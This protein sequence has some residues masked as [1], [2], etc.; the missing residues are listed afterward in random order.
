M[1]MVD[2][3]CFGPEDIA[4]NPLTL[5]DVLTDYGA[6]YG[7]YR[8]DMYCIYLPYPCVS[9]HARAWAWFQIIKTRA[10]VILGEP[11]R[12]GFAE[13]KDKLAKSNPKLFV[14]ESVVEFLVYRVHEDHLK[15][16]LDL[17]TMAEIRVKS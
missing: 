9:V 13:A 1:K 8:F 4:A 11:W 17:W 12:E 16:F 3:S 14:D 5:V 15:E 6:Y 10:G 2:R 7:K